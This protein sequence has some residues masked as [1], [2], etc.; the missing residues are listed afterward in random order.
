MCGLLEDACLKMHSKNMLV[1][2]QERQGPIVS[3]QEPRTAK[4]SVPRGPPTNRHP[5]CSTR[6]MG[7]HGITKRG[8]AATDQAKRKQGDCCNGR[9][10]QHDVHAGGGLDL[11][12]LRPPKGVRGRQHHIQHHSA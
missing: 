3:R 5:S 11:L 6:R 10:L 8:T 9:H 1:H 7:Y 4:L 12:I 2:I